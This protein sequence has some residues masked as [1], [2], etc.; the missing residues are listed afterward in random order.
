M[1]TPEEMLQILINKAIELKSCEEIAISDDHLTEVS[2]EDVYNATGKK[3]YFKDGK[4]LRETEKGSQEWLFFVLGGIKQE[5]RLENI[6]KR[7][8]SLENWT[9]QFMEYVEKRLNTKS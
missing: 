2:L 6:E 4:I 8:K 9:H 3:I 7:L 1:K 5:D